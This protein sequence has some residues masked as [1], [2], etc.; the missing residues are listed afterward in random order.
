M[1]LRLREA[2]RDVGGWDA[3]GLSGQESAVAGFSADP[4]QGPTPLEV[5]RRDESTGGIHTWWW[6]SGDGGGS[7]ERHPAHTYTTS[8]VY[9]V[10][11]SMSGLG[12][13]DTV[14]R[15]NRF[16]TYAAA[17]AGFSRDPRSG[18]ALLAVQ[19]TDESTGDSNTW[20]WDFGNGSGSSDHHPVH[21]STIAGTYTVTRV[22][23]GPGGSDNEVK[24]NYMSVHEPP[25]PADRRMY[26]PEIF[27][28]PW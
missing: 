16:A 3:P 8:G 14:T 19:F 1:A 10:T 5:Q 21:T 15:T 4:I 26:L 23:G 25:P 2:R 9:T 17:V 20:A 13:T 28:S 22:I 12:G 6:Q 11:L 24:R 27:R 18:P 7:S